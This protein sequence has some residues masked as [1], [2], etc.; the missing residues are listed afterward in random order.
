MDNLLKL[1]SL[2]CYFC[3]NWKLLVHLLFRT[4]HFGT[5]NEWWSEHR[6]LFGLPL[7]KRFNI[8]RNFRLA[9]FRATACHFIPPKEQLLLFPKHSDYKKDNDV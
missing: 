9:R 6:S 3:A 5:N 2:I 8:I 7:A 4:Y 1:K